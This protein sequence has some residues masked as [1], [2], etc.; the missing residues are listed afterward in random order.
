[1]RTVILHSSLPLTPFVSACR[2]LGP[3][4]AVA[5]ADHRLQL[6]P[7]GGGDGKQP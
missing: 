2:G 3:V 4:E 7:A 1:M 5:S 6:N